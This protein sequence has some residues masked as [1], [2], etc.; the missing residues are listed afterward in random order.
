LAL[1]DSYTK[2]QGIPWGS[3]FPNQLRDS[4]L[5]E[6]ITTEATDPIIVAQTGWR[7]DQLL[8][9]YRSQ[10]NLSSKVVDLVTLCIG[11][12]NQFQNRNQEEYQQELEELLQIAIERTGN[13]PERV[14]VVSIPDW[15][16]TP[17][18]Q[19]Y[20]GFGGPFGITSQVDQFNELKR[21]S[22]LAVGASYVYIT[23]L[24]REG[25]EK[26]DWVASDG[27]HPSEAQ[28]SAWLSKRILPVIRTLLDP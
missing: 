15:A 10:P 20:P 3:N 26:P 24:S 16:F 12:N 2:G 8:A 7:T 19:N 6:G 11:V 21:S 23:D 9:A 28:Y 25:L 18:G 22:A 5:A 27:L 13:R 1:G 14:L 17:F 4:L